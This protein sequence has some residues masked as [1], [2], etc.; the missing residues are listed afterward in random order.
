MTRSKTSRKVYA[1][2]GGRA[3]KTR[4]EKA[5]TQKKKRS[6]VRDAGDGTRARARATA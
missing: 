2:A 3:S 4:I 5:D 1:G 6:I